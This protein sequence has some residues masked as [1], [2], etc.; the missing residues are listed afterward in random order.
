MMPIVLQQPPPMFVACSSSGNNNVGYVVMCA[1]ASTSLTVQRPHPQWQLRSCF[2]RG[3]HPVTTT[4][5][6][7]A[8]CSPAK[9]SSP[10]RRCLLAI[11]Q[12]SSSS[13]LALPQLVPRRG[14]L[15]V[16]LA[17]SLPFPAAAA[18][19]VVAPLPQPS[20]LRA[21]GLGDADIYYPR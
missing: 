14:C 12:C 10:H 21:L 6:T 8:H 7:T 3:S 9:C 17:A 15:L 19:S 4:T 1:H 13:P 11:A 16:L 20:F 5:T 18:T 2:V